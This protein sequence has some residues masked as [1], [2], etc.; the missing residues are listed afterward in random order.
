MMFLQFVIWGAWFEIG[1]SYIPN[2]GFPEPWMTPLVFGA[3]NIGAWW[4]FSSARSSL[5]ATT[6]LRIFSR[7][8][9]SSVAWQLWDCSSCTLKAIRKQPFGRSSD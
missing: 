2:L 4:P 3:F 7:S 1:F 9:I 5:I 6:P 8:A